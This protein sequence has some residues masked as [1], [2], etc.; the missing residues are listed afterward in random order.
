MW[1]EMLHTYS[2]PLG[3]HAAG[4]TLDLPDLY[5]KQMRAEHKKKKL[6]APCRATCPP[7]QRHVDKDAQRIA[8]LKAQ[9]VDAADRADALGLHVHDAMV[10]ADSLVA[11][12]TELQRESGQAD[13]AAK[14][15]IEAS[16]KKN[17]SDAV[18]KKAFGLARYSERLSAER[19]IAAGRLSIALAESALAKL[20][21]AEAERKAK[22][23]AELVVEGEGEKKEKEPEN[24]QEPETGQPKAEQSKAEQPKAEQPKAE[25]PAE[26]DAVP[27]GQ[28]VPAGEKSEPL[29]DQ[30]K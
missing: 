5:V 27:E 1:I 10:K 20:D 25:Q 17:A 11:P 16:R 12:A 22:R 6:P 28:A 18:K 8:E 24:E 30:V 13:K 19:Q 15:T 9:A 7:W 26:G 29:P 14:K 3:F 4:E 2:G 23:L 21:A